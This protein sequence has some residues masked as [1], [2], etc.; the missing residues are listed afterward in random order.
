MPLDAT[1]FGDSP[2]PLLRHTGNRKGHGDKRP[3]LFAQLRRALV[4][5][6]LHFGFDSGRGES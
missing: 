5:S 2:R 6:P 4:P 1:R 3:S